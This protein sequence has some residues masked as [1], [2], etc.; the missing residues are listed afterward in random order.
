MTGLS[1]EQLWDITRGRYGVTDAP[2]PIC[3]PDR[4]SPVNRQRAVLRIWC[5][6]PDLLTYHCSRCPVS[7]YAVT[8]GEVSPS[9]R[10]ISPSER[11]KIKAE[12]ERLEALHA[13]TQ[14]I[15]SVSL[16]RRR[17]APV[18]E[19]PV[20][21]YL[22]QSRGYGGKIPAT[23][24]YLPALYDFPPA[25]I[26]AI[27]MARE[28]EPGELVIDDDAIRGVHITS[29]KPDGSG[30][31]GTDRD[32]I[33]I[34]RSLGSPIILAPPN[35]GLG[36]AITEGIEDALSVNEATGLGA[37]AAGSAS[38]MPALAEVVPDYIECV[39]IVA[40]GDEA[41]TTNA[42]KLADALAQRS[43][44][45]RLIVPSNDRRAA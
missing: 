14:L 5:D 29:L 40:D 3:G 35:D 24:G 16:W 18:P 4:R 25:M 27:G 13:K 42:K 10:T 38:R 41:G 26:A 33:M 17:L 28:T 30:K 36:L 34:G 39:S 11:G 43:C 8:G 21:T 32:K 37:W 15:K 12:V 45:T 9:A 20:H 2:C 1:F 31:A 7:G 23:I 19:T 6:D 22:R 44:E